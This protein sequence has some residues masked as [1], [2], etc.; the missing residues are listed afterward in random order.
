MLLELEDLSLDSIK[1]NNEL[2]HLP[3]FKNNLYFTGLQLISPF[4]SNLKQL[5]SNLG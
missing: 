2:F 3:R 4:A 5:K 1:M